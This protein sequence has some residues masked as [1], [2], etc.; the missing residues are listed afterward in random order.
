MT[1]NAGPGSADTAPRPHSAAA[2]TGTQRRCPRC[3]LSAPV[4]RFH[5]CR[6]KNVYCVTC[7]AEYLRDRYAAKR[8][9][10]GLTYTARPRSATL[11]IGPPRILH[12]GLAMK[13][14]ICKRGHIITDATA[15]ARGSKR[16][17]GICKRDRSRE[18][19]RPLRTHCKRGH[20]L[21]VANTR[22]TAGGSRQCLDCKTFVQAARLAA[23]GVR[24][25]PDKPLVEHVA[26]RLVRDPWVARIFGGGK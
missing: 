20:V 12:G 4:V 7:F 3:K 26:Y 15:Y 22:I 24:A 23:R 11:G 21:T 17:C 9:A 18:R 14:G 19:P 6:G 1:I 13:R 5:T 25:M 10:R 2:G 8:L 16:Q